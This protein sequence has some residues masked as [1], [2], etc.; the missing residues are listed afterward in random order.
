M[1]VCTV[2]HIKRVVS[3]DRI[4]SKE[5]EEH[6]IFGGCAHVRVCVQ[7]RSPFQKESFP[8]TSI[9]RTGRDNFVSS[10]ARFLKNAKKMKPTHLSCTRYNAGFST[11]CVVQHVINGFLLLFATVRQSWR[12]LPFLKIGLCLCPLRNFLG[13]SDLFLLNLLLLLL[14]CPA[15]ETKPPKT[16]L[17]SA[18]AIGI[19][20]RGPQSSTFS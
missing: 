9:P 11:T 5:R 13:A 12:A 16:D 15:K 19:R 3:I 20:P 14:L 7:C 18:P 1:C 6:L 2:V 17:P 8:P 4:P 10:G